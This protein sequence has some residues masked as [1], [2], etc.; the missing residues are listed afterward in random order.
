MTDYSDVSEPELISSCFDYSQLRADLADEVREAAERVR[1]FTLAAVIEVGRELLLVKKRLKHGQFAAWVKSECAIHMRAAQRAMRAAEMV[2]KNDKLSYLPADGLLALAS[3]SAPE[4][5]V[6]QIID[7]V[8]QEARFSAA[9]IKRRI[10]Q[11][12]PPTSRTRRANRIHD[13]G[14]QC[15]APPEANNADSAAHFGTAAP[16]NPID[17]IRRLTLTVA[18]PLDVIAALILDLELADR[19]RCKAWLLAHTSTVDAAASSAKTSVASV[20]EPPSPTLRPGNQD[21]M[22][23]TEKPDQGADVLSGAPDG[24]DTSGMG[25]PSRDN[26]LVQNDGQAATLR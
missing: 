21:F 5:V 25:L 3:R 26:E 8:E 2:E 22:S 12:R 10:E 4:E 20:D 11:A 7:A 9:Q 24:S 17:T 16:T 15:L 19:E 23:S 6:A 18:D 13:V 1:G 14:V